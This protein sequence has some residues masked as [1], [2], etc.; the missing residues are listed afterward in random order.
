MN[1]ICFLLL[2]FSLCGMGNI[3]AYQVSTE[4]QKRN[5]LLEEFT[6]IHCGYCAKGHA[7]GNRLKVAQPERVYVVAAY[8]GSFS[9]PHKDEPDFRT[10]YGNYLC[11]KFCVNSFPSGMVNRKLF[12][13][14]SDR[15]LD[16]GKWT[17]YAKHICGDDA[18][19]NLWMKSEYDGE[20]RLLKVYVEGYYTKTS[21]KANFL[22][23]V[24]TQNNGAV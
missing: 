12:E 19:V 20:E 7:I 10:D 15:V 16:R 4:F 21:E 3:M 13:E 9:I 8:T 11:S 14:E 17:R 18:L 22:N 24:W 1:K 2:Y 23:V 5:I 6:G